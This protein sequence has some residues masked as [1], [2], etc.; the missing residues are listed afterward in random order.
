MPG[1]LDWLKGIGEGV[2]DVAEGAAELATGELQGA[3]RGLVTGEREDKSW[4]PTRN[5]EGGGSLLA[6]LLRDLGVPAGWLEPEGGWRRRDYGGYAGS[7]VEPSMDVWDEDIGLTEEQMQRRLLLRSVYAGAVE[8]MMSQGVG[9]VLGSEGRL[10]SEPDALPLTSI[11]MM[12]MLRPEIRDDFFE[13]AENDEELWDLMETATDPSEITDYVTGWLRRHREHP[14]LPGSG[15]D[16]ERAEG[17]S[18]LEQIDMLTYRG[19]Q[20]DTRAAQLGYDEAML[21]R[22]ARFAQEKLDSVP[23]PKRAEFSAAVAADPYWSSQFFPASSP[24]GPSPPRRWNEGMGQRRQLDI[25]TGKVELMNDL[26]FAD[27]LDEFGSPAVAR[28]YRQRAEQG[29]P[30]GYEKRQ[31][32]QGEPQPY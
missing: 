18:M 15:T 3:V 11:E 1:P 22:K 12:L 29:S 2:G 24:Y 17:S 13:K 7:A 19:T 16:L 5:I 26:D 23:W 21:G 6:F 31:P 8:E 27:L 14:G 4:F 28:A 9:L 32:A 30:L 20:A 10:K 25:R